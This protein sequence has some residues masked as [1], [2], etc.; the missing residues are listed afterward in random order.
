MVSEEV[1]ISE[2]DILE[3]VLVVEEVLLSVLLDDVD[4]E[5]DV[6]VEDTVEELVAEVE[7]DEVEVEVEVEVEEGGGIQDIELAENIK[8]PLLFEFERS[9]RI[10]AETSPGQ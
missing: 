2:V 4:I 10:F 8:L 9:K 6:D 1:E 7:E 5:V 3:D